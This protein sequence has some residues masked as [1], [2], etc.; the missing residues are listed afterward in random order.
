[1]VINLVLVFIIYI[2]FLEMKGCVLEDMDVLFGGYDLS[3][4]LEY[5]L[6]DGEDE[7]DD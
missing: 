1:M 7:D 5:L 2:F 4:L 6:V 3:V